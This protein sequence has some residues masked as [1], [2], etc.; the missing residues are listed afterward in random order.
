MS[1]PAFAPSPLYAFMMKFL[2]LLLAAAATI[3]NAHP[4]QVLLNPNDEPKWVPMPP[5][6]LLPEPSNGT[7]GPITDKVILNWL[8]HI[9][10]VEINQ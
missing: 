7:A 1:Y 2:G 4:A 5:G 6:I 8:L 3:A 10:Q 9:Q